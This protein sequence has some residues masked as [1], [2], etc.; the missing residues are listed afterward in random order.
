M[1]CECHL[2]KKETV[3]PEF[4]QLRKATCFLKNIIWFYYFL[5]YLLIYLALLGLCCGMID[6]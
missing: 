4:S 1:L 2:R 5:K 6:L 3:L